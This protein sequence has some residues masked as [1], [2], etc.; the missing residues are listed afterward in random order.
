MTKSQHKTPTLKIR[1]EEINR[2]IESTG[3]LFVQTIDPNNYLF[4]PRGLEGYDKLK[5]RLLGLQPI[6]ISPLHSVNVPAQFVITQH[7]RPGGLLKKI[8]FWPAIIV[9][10]ILVFYILVFAMVALISSKNL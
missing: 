9:G 8:F 7:E 4:V 6:E 10:S 3:G 1:F 5:E 2:I